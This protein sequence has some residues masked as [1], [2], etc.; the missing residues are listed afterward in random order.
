MDRETII[1]HFVLG[2][3]TP[4]KFHNS[5]GV[6]FRGPEACVYDVGKRRR[7]RH[8]D[9]MWHENSHRHHICTWDDFTDRDL[10]LL[11]E[12]EGGIL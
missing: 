10:S 5:F 2:G 12:I 11:F 7:H 6:V 8:S 3:W 9:A 4:L 1:S